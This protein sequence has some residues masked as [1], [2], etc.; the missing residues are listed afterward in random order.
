MK[1]ARRDSF[2]TSPSTGIVTF[3]RCLVLVSVFLCA[4]CASIPRQGETRHLIRVEN[5]T[6]SR[7]RAYASFESSP[8][9]RVLLGTLEP[10]QSEFFPLPNVFTENRGL[11]VSCEK[12]RSNGLQ[13]ANM[14]YQ[15]SSVAL[16][17]SSMLVV[18]IREPIDYSD[19][20]IYSEE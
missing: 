16:P 8:E 4:A 19:F 13:R 10:N 1:N 3:V 7:I 11:I 14:C 12:G 17:K 18:R 2:P 15:T 6:L 5:Q 20:T 9:V